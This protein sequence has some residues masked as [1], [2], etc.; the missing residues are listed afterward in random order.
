MNITNESL[1]KQAEDA[2]AMV[3]TRMA[4]HVAPGDDAAR[5]LEYWRESF[6]AAFHHADIAW[7]RRAHET[8]FAELQLFLMP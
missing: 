6:A 2:A 3:A 7:I 4:A 1:I 8:A 5:A